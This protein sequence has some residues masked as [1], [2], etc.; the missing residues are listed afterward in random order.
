MWGS[1]L[2]ERAEVSL[3]SI[4][5]FTYDLHLDGAPVE[6]P[7]HSP[8]AFGTDPINETRHALA[9]G[10]HVLAIRVEDPECFN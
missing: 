8:I 3:F 2:P 6:R 9:A 4:A 1:D 7:V 5:N 10:R